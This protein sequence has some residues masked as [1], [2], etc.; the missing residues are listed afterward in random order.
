[1]PTKQ[2]L[3]LMKQSLINHIVLVIDESGSMGGIEKQTIQVFDSQIKYLAQRSQELNQETRVT[4]YLFDNQTSCIIYD[5]DVLRLPSL[6]DFYKP[7][8]GTALIDATTKALKDLE[9]TPQMYGDHAFLMYVLTDGGENASSYQNKSNFPALISNLPSNWTVA[10]LVPDQTGVHE[11][12]KFGFPADNIQV[13]DTSAKG[14]AEVGKKIQMATESFMQY[15]KAAPPGQFRGTKS[16]FK[17]DLSNLN[18]QTVK[19]SLDKLAHSD[20]HILQVQYDAPIREYIER[21]IGAYNTGAGYYQLTKREEVQGYKQICIYEK[22][23]GNVY[24][25]PQARKLVGLDT[26]ALTKVSPEAHPDYDI[27]IQSTSVNRKLITGS[28]VIVLK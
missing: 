15:R 10:V 27:F 14:M 7:N 9:H 28:R 21:Q 3:E 4:V 22:K 24:T 20:Y 11:A 12:K 23:T 8:G 5:K 25:G 1:M 6:A 16:L 13:W 26:T 19:T 17:L 18:S 2:A